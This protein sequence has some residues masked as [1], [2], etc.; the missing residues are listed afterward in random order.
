MNSILKKALIGGLAALTFG[1]AVAETSTPALA[2]RGGWHGGGFHGGWGGGW[3][4]GG[5]GGWRGRG[6]GWGGVG[7]GLALGAAAAGAAYTWGWPNYGY[8]PYYGYGAYG[9][10]WQQRPVYDYFGNF[11]GYRPV[12]VC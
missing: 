11:R 5:G 4:G 8:D 6:W 7:A 3:R 12:A 2:F 9:G 10:C 1:L